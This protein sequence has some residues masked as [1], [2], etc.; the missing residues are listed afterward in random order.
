MN[1]ALPGAPRSEEARLSILEATG[2]LVESY[3]YPR[4][5][6]EGVAREAKVGKQTIYRWWS[7]K[8][9]LVVEALEEGF[10]LPISVHPPTTKDLRS[11]LISWLDSLVGL[12]V[13]K[14]HLLTLRAIFYAAM[15]DTEACKKLKTTAGLTAK[16]QERVELAQQQGNLRASLDPAN[17]IEALLGTF[18]LHAI[19]GPPLDSSSIPRLVDLILSCPDCAVS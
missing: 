4:L 19:L 17:I 18:V 2:K 11:D 1:P 14:R 6:I 13:D 7:N 16:G 15:D 10:L 3:G 5:T 8:A 9:L 12:T